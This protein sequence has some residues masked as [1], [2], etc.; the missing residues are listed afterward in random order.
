MDVD[1]A[2]RPLATP[3]KYS[4]GL[5]GDETFLALRNAGGSGLFP[6]DDRLYLRFRNGRLAGWRGD[7]G[8]NWMWQ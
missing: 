5:P 4:S 6:Q 8:H 1:D 2:E 3:L 7:W